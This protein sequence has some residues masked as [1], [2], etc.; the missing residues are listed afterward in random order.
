MRK[1]F[2]V[3]VSVSAGELRKV[4]SIWPAMRLATREFAQPHPH[5]VDPH[6]VVQ[7]LFEVV[8]PEHED[9]RV[10]SAAIAADDREG[11]GDRIDLAAQDDILTDL[12]A[13]AMHRGGTHHRA[14]AM[15]LKTREGIG[16]EA[17]F[18]PHLGQGVGIDRDAGKLMLG[19]VVDS[20]EPGHPIHRDDVVHRRDFLGVRFGQSI[21]HRGLI[22]HH[23]TRRGI[24]ARGDRSVM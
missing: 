8:A 6:R 11:Q 9:R 10:A 20:G 12:P 21:A 18:G 22:H 2:S 24:G 5:H 3:S 14:V 16:A 17:V 7:R 4:E 23:Q 13:E 1:A 15:G 19:I